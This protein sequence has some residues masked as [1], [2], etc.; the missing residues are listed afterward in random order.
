MEGDAVSLV[1][2]DEIPM[3]DEIERLINHAIPREFIPGFEPDDRISPATLRAIEA[4]RRGGAHGGSGRRTVGR[5]RGR[6]G[7]RTSG[8]VR[9]RAVA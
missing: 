1:S 7:G 3:L 5:G 2:L 6:G 4:S 9:R 8:S